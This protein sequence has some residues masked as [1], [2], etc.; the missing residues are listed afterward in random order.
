MDIGELKS[1]IREKFLELPHAHAVSFDQIAVRC[2]F[3]GDSRKDPN[4]TRFYIK[5]NPNN[6]EPILYNCFNCG[7]SGILTPSVMRT[8]EISDLS[9][10]SKLL[11]F[12]KGSIKK[13]KKEF[14]ISDNK[15]DFKV[16]IP[17]NIESN[18]IKKAYINE[19]LGLSLS[20]RELMRLKAVFS[21]KEFIVQNNIKELTISQ[22]RASLLDRDYV[23]FLSVR[24][25]FIICRDITNRNKLRYD[26]YSV[27][28]NID[29]TR[30]FYSIPTSIDIM[31]NDKI[32]I[33]L[34][35]GVYDILGVYFHV[36][37]Q[38]DKNN[39]YV[40]VSGSA[41]A[42]VIKYFIQSGIFGDNV[43][44]NIYSDKDKEPWFYKKIKN[45]LGIWFNDIRLFYNEYEKDFGVPK[46][47]IS[48]ITKRIR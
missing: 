48:V 23:G 35:E 34:A 36:K 33:N 45:E 7:V 21:L 40:A 16:P 2:E 39:V 13:L 6:D 22:D 32:N 28:K 1:D 42:S 12:N 14:G 8:F 18:H 20:F 24:N 47:K 25:E 31:T 46:E 15:F 38:N 3:C 11:G 17:A 26:K 27:F 43:T 44:V 5:I 9:T 41:Y 37:N 29:N 4:K 10:N 30:K 19:R